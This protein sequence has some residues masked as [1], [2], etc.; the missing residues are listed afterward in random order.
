MAIAQLDRLRLSLIAAHADLALAT[1]DETYPE[2]AS[3]GAEV[4]LSRAAVQ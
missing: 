3:T 2:A 4:I 1:L